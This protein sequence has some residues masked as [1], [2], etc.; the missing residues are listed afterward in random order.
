MVTHDR[1]ID[2]IDGALYRFLR[3][4]GIE[5]TTEAGRIARDFGIEVSA[6]AIR[7]HPD[8]LANAP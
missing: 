4:N 6:E 8:P 5:A 2:T 1:E 7:R 3:A